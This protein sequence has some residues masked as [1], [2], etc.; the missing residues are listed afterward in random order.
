MTLH[1]GAGVM[2]VLANNM[3]VLFQTYRLRVTIFGSGASCF[4]VHV[5]AHCRMLL[6]LGINETQVCSN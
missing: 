1:E 6:V 5:P 3:C 2:A 4:A